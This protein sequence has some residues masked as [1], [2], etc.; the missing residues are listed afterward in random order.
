MYRCGNCTCGKED[1]GESVCI[2]AGIVLAER[3]GRAKQHVLPRELYVRK[4]GWRRKR[5]Y[6]CGDCTCGKRRESENAYKAAWIV[7][8]GKVGR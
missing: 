6:Y 4:R 3:E 7:P 1:G 5:M 8:A 2:T